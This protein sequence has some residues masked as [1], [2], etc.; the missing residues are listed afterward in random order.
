MSSYER[1]AYCPE[2][3]AKVTLRKR[4]RLGQIVTCR[5]CDTRLEVIDVMPLEFD[6][7][8]EDAYDYDQID[9]MSDE[10]DGF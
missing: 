3:N 6:W 9:L 5:Q 10:Y 2:C 8:F 7:A 4:P 1:T